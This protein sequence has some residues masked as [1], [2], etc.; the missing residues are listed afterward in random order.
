VALLPYPSSES[1]KS[2]G[3]AP[4]P[5]RDPRRSPRPAHPAWG[6]WPSLPATCPGSRRC[7]ASP[8]RAL[9]ALIGRPTPAPAGATLRPRLLALVPVLWVVAFGRVVQILA[10][11]R[12]LLER[13]VLVGAEVM[14]H[15]STVAAVSL[16]ARRSKSRTLA[17]TSWAQKTPV[18][19]HSRVCTSHSCSSVRRTV[20]SA[21]ARVPV[22]RGSDTAWPCSCRKR[23]TRPPRHDGGRVLGQ[24]LGTE[25]VVATPAWASGPLAVGR[26][27]WCV[28]MSR[29]TMDALWCQEHGGGCWARAQPPGR[30]RGATEDSFY[31]LP[32]A[33]VVVN[34]PGRLGKTCQVLGARAA[35]VVAKTKPAVIYASCSATIKSRSHLGLPAG[36]LPVSR[37]AR[38]LPPGRGRRVRVGSQRSPP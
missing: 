30:V 37:D 5:I 33:L 24:D 38:A 19:S 9:S 28:A 7:P 13:E 22:V 29:S 21:V 18:G 17:L 27:C 36:R 2:P 12:M 31:V 3:T 35:P 15:S 10:R 23:G 6:G 11:Q 20:S 14:D 16:P 4:A 8:C 25:G 26:P 34:T 1:A 32:L